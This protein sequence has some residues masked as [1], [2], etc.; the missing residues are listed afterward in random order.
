M[1]NKKKRTEFNVKNSRCPKAIELD[2]CE[3]WFFILCRH[4][5]VSL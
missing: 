4:D 2:G 1:Q 5:A 3:L